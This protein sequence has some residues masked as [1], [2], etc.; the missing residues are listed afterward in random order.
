SGRSPQRWGLRQQPDQGIVI[1]RLDQMVMKARFPRAATI[2]LPPV[3]GNGDE[4]RRLADVL[5][6]KPG[7]HLV[8]V[9]SRQPDIEQ[10]ELRPMRA[11]GLD[12]VGAVRCGP[13]I[14]A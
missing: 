7:D 1:D 3:S 14:M 2:V 11:R 13:D 8:A 5:L 12:R 9:H 10:D 6:A 4:Y